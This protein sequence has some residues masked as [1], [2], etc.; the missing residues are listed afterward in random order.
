MRANLRLFLAVVATALFIALDLIV[1]FYHLTTEGRN[2]GITELALACLL[3]PLVYLA[4]VAGKK[5][6][7]PVIWRFLRMA[8]QAIMLMAAALALFLGIY[9]LTHEGLRSGVIETT[10]SALLLLLGYSLSRET[11]GRVP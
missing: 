4:M 2:S 6:G 10:M 1:A 8:V 7:G 11:K 3:I 5:E 9:H